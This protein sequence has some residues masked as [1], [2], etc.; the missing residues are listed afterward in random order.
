MTND[1]EGGAPSV[2]ARDASA[3]EGAAGDAGAMAPP[4][5][6]VDVT[7]ETLQV[8]AEPRTFVL[9]TP[10]GYDPAKSYPLVMVFHGD[11]GNGAGMRTSYRYDDQ[12]G[13]AAFVVY[14][15]SKAGFSWDL[16]T[17]EAQNADNAFMV[18]IVAALAARF[19]IDTARVFG[20]GYS[21]GAFFIN[22]IACR[23]TGFFRAIAPN[24]GGAPREPQDP[25]ATYWK[26]DYTKCANQTGGV[27][28]IV[29]HGTDDTT[30]VPESGDF[31]AQYWAYLNGC[32]EAKESRIATTPAP[33]TM[34]ASCPV[35]Q[36]VVYC[37]I[38]NIGHGAWSES[39]KASWAFFQSL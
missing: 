13:D 18:A 16:Y 6:K 33:C 38:P 24:A 14:P 17:P 8:F 19:P 23:K 4:P 7:N 12:T 26:P 3:S 22:Q 28:A 9:V 11:G 21:S 39:A 29:F 5:P 36:P 34:H 10:K 25:S 35:G 32:D 31:T 20:T 27:A 15:D 30:V 2:V 1:T 37:P